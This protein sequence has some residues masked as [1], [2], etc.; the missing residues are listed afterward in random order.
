MVVACDETRKVSNVA[1]V[2]TFNIRGTTERMKK[3][4]IACDA[5]NNK[6]PIVSIT[7]TDTPMTL[8]K[9]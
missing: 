5:Y 4:I 1:K 2:T 6:A 9:K 7:E 3:D 8:H